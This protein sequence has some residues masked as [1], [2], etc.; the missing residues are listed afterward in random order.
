M[1]VLVTG[2][3]TSCHR[4]PP[5]GPNDAYRDPR[6]S[7][8]TWHHFFEDPGRGEIYQ[9]RDVIVRL[10]AP[11]PGMTVADVGAG[12]GLF[13]MM[14]STAVGPTGRVYAEEV[15]EKFSRHIAERAVV[16]QRRNVVSVVGTEL[17]IGL[18]PDS[19]DLAF[20]CD[21]YHH[22]DHPTEMLA[23][24]WRALRPGGELFVVDFKR[25]PGKSPAW[26][27]E[28]VRADEATVIREI[29]AAGFVS[30]AV[31][32]TLHDSYALRFRRRDGE[33]GTLGDEGSRLH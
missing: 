33:P 1:L 26:V 29:E 25:E 6:I 27:F 30:I 32:H 15:E 24:I 22:F 16:E 11:K 19:I 28:H 14:L 4:R 17:G 31:D 20:V 12:T 5:P 9:Q 3:L 10:A 2:L 7:A 8:E 13:T 18:P 23:S 21:V